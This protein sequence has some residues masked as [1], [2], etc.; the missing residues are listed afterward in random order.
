LP[1]TNTLITYYSLLLKSVNYGSK[2]F[3]TRGPKG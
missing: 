2:Q 3:Y 1:G